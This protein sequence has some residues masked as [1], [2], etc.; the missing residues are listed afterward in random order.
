[1]ALTALP[2]VIV[3]PNNVIQLMAVAF[4]K[5][6]GQGYDVIHVEAT[7]FVSF[8]RQVFTVISGL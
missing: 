5:Q 1:M 2:A 3:H 8:D 7:I 6:D 4:V